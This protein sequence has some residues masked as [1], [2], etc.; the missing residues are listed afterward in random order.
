MRTTDLQSQL[1]SIGYMEAK[2][3]FNLVKS[4]HAQAYIYIYVSMY[5]CMYLLHA[6]VRACIYVCVYDAFYPRDFPDILLNISYTLKH[7]TCPHNFAY[8]YLI[9]EYK[10]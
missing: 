8:I 6:C 2:I 7:A 3:H 9:S 5:A 1:C 10:L 4:R